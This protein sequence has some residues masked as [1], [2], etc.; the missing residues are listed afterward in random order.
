MAIGDYA[1]IGDL[2]SAALVSR[3][4]SIDWLCLPRFDSPACFAALLG[5]KD[6]GHWTIAPSQPVLSSR[7]S[8]RPDTLILET[9]FRTESGVAVVIDFMPPRDEIADLVRIVRCTEGS[10]DFS[11]VLRIRSDYGRVLP[12]VR[13]IDRGIAAVAGPDAFY[14]RGDVELKGRDHS[15]VADFT[16]SSGEQVSFVFSRTESHLPEPA[17][18]DPGSALDDTVSYWRE[19]ISGCGYSGRWAAQVRRSLI[20]LKALTYRPTGGIVAAAT[21]SLPENRGGIRNWDYRY[22]WLRDSTFTL[23]ALVSCGYTDEAVAWRHWLLRAIG[24]DPAELQV[25]YTIDGA[26]RIAECELEWLPGFANSKPVRIG[27]AAARQFQLDIFGEVL[28]TLDLARNTGL[29]EH[30]H[31][32]SVDS[33]WAVQRLLCDAV[34]T[35]W[36]QPDEG[37]WEIRGEPRHFVHSKVMAWVAMDRMVHGAQKHGLDGPIAQWRAIRDEIHAE[38]CE[39]GFNTE[40]GHFVQSYGSDQLDA[41]L[42][43]LPRVGFLPWD[44]PRI[45][46]TVVAVRDELTDNSGFIR[47]YRPEKPSAGDGLSDGEGSF[48]ACSF[49]MVDALAGIGK[50]AEAEQLFERLLSVANDVGLISEEYDA[51][52]ATQLGN[53]P[54]AYSHVG[55]INAARRLEGSGVNRDR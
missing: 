25:L 26:R 51:N 45:V 34:A 21:T 11:G 44:D 52:T 3:H 41:A 32:D 53:V 49:W 12:W 36:R 54:Q 10:V 17:S 6:N 16:V 27:N 14:L 50:R 35:M 29:T 8:Y 38:V 7:R 4:G 24:G 48:L 31:A 1:L 43:L 20:T 37:L 9:E 13:H 47:R 18:I 5:T 30:T 19:W 55:L 33:S 28:D 39:R 46:A 22:C 40:L 15:T 42:L 23:E 2:H